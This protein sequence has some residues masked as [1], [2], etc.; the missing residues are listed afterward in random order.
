MRGDAAVVEG[1]MHIDWTVHSRR[2]HRRHNGGAGGDSEWRQR[3]HR[4]HTQFLLHHLR[5]NQY[6]HRN[7][8]TPYRRLCKLTKAHSLTH[9]RPPPR[10]FAR[11][12]ANSITDS[13]TQLINHFSH[14]EWT[15]KVC[16]LKPSIF[17]YQWT[18]LKDDRVTHLCAECYWI[19]YTASYRLCVYIDV[20]W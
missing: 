10:P 11:S 8:D 18:Q 7:V 15:T 16:L 17:L 19:N 14:N 13:I 1:P 9:S 20:W 6:C 2:R 12:L 5:R 3:V 4:P